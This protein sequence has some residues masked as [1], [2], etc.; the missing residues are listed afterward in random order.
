MSRFD[1]LLRDHGLSLYRG[2]AM[3]LQLNLGRECNLACRHCHLECGPTRHEAMARQTMAQLASLAASYRF[4]TIDI[5]GG[6]PELH[7]DLPMLIELL[8]PLAGS[9]LLRS[10]LVALADPARAARLLDVAQRHG[11]T[12]VASLPAT[13][14]GSTDRIRGAGTYDASVTMLRE[15]NRRGFGL[16]GSSLE[17]Q[18]VHNPGGAF[19]PGCQSEMEA[20]YRQRLQQDFGIVFTRL[21]AMGNVPLGRFR[22]WLE[23]TGQLDAYLDTLAR[24][25]NP[26]AVAGLMCREIVSVDWDGSV[27]DCDFNLAAGLPVAGKL[28][29]DQLSPTVLAGLEGQPIA[30]GDH[31]LACT[32]GAGFT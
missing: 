10:N 32:A 12:I 29:V 9:M 30:T 23:A 14:Q 24:D 16:P 21:L 3:V 25:F 6:A 8:A 20:H 17:L 31:C 1:Q 13:D 26:A 22:R 11:L 7:P 5:T 18:L 28:Q 19:L 2:R 27:H 15:L 4:R